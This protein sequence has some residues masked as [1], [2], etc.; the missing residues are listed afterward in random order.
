MEEALKAK[1]H[2][3]EKQQRRLAE[4]QAVQAGREVATRLQSTHL[5]PTPTTAGEPQLA[6]DVNIEPM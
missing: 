6:T 5:G 3:Y 4:E 2:E 1:Q